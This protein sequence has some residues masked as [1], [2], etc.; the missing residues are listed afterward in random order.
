MIEALNSGE[1]TGARLDVY[2]EEPPA[3]DNSLFEVNN[4]IVTPHVAVHSKATMV[5]MATH[6]TQGIIE[7][8]NGGLLLSL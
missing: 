1:I 5:K 4:I 8:L 6:A 7:L 2:A 3:A